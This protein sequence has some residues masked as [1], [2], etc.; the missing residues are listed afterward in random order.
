MSATAAS[1]EA[2]GKVNLFLRVVAREATGH[3]QLE[4]L[5]TRI[6]LSDSVSIATAHS[7]REL[8]VTGAEVGPRDENLAWRAALAY[9]EAAGWPTGFRIE[10]TK[11]LPVG[12]G[13]G[14]G[15]ADAGAV[16]RALN[17]LNPKP[18]A[19]A[20]LASVAFGLGA[21]VPFLTSSAVLALGWGRGERL[22]GLR[23]LPARE[24]VLALPGF[25]VSTAAAFGWY[26]D[27][28]AKRAAARTP[29]SAPARA[30]AR[31]PAALTIEDLDRWDAV[32]RLAANDL[33]DV[34]TAQHPTIETCRRFL[35][36]A[37]AKIARMSGSGAS[38]F[39]IFDRRPTLDSSRLP[40]GVELLQTRTSTSVAA[41]RLLD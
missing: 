25:S 16:L 21:D 13:L 34:V 18:L 39:G 35:E 37:G 20:V 24:V 31:A 8:V 10:V 3:H 6:E 30:P 19:D 5:F 1:I 17:A 36:G 28:A 27:A 11:R 23:P 14:G 40:E 38:V 2:Q 41:V 33:E 29:A 4:T 32:A 9:A 15:S 22:L 12:G 26:A 7:A